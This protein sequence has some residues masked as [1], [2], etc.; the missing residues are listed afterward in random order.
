MLI[1]R[2]VSPEIPHTSSWRKGTKGK[3]YLTMNTFRRIRDLTGAKILQSDALYVFI[4][5]P[6]ANQC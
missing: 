5:S 6:H 2:G 3:I 4:G 1:K